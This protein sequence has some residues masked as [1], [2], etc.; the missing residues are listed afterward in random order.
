M[1]IMLKS[2]REERQQTYSIF[3]PIHP[4]TGRVLYVP[5]KQVDAA[6]GTITFD[7]EDG[8]GMD[9]AG[10]RRQRE[11]AVEARFRRALGGAGRRFR[12]VRQGPFHQHADL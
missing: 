8:P 1:K 4:E 5:M 7:D 3:L 10:H 2:L 11:A 9:A 6:E 12:D